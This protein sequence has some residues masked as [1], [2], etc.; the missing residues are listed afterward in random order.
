VNEAKILFLDDMK[1]RHGAFTR[2]TDQMGDV[3]VW[4]AY[5]AAEAIRLLSGVTF[6]QAFLDHDLSE[7]DIMVD[8]SGPS[9]VP[10]GMTVVDH[11]LTMENPPREVFVHTCN[12][13]AGDEMERRLKSHPARIIV[14]RFPFPHLIHAM[15]QSGRGSR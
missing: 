1:T 9:K 5:D 2:L 12:P 13:A 6:D 8:P 4:Q 3:R 15:E 7:E 11:I 14:H 10:T